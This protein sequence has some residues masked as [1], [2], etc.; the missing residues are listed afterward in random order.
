MVPVSVVIITKNT[1]DIITGCLERA[2]QLTDDIII[3]CNGSDEEALDSLVKNT[4]RVY[5]RQWDGYGANKNKGVDAAKYNWILSI[6]ADEIPDDELI[7]ALHK[8]DLGNIN[9]VYDIRFRSYFG[10]KLIRYGSWGRDHHLRLF[11][12]RVV[13]W[14]ETMVHET[15]ILPANIQRKKLSGAIHHYSV[16][17]AGE[18]DSKGSYYARLSA[19]KYFRSG[20]KAGI[21]KL[22]ISPI[23][24]FFKNY[25]VWMG[26]LDGREGWDI[27]KTTVKNTRRK[28]H[29]LNQ[30]ELHGDNKQPAKENLVVEY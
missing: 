3:I 15:L 10:G 12:R 9:V 19:K 21:I 13:K 30:M 8:T 11:N 6:D 16:K 27:A 26:F 23:F 29:F 1:T 7:S 20:K 25:I 17:N 4:C 5:K 28:Y 22:Y 18:F 14:S 24:G 2:R